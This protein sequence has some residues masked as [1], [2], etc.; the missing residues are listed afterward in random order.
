MLTFLVKPPTILQQTGYT[1]DEIVSVARVIGTTVSED[2]RV[3]SSGRT[4]GAVQR[5]YGTV[6]YGFVSVDF[7]PPNVSD[8]LG[9]K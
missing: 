1:A 7:R 6:H 4:L 3:A 2:C 5:K 9:P 8:I